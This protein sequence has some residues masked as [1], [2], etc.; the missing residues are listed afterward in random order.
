MVIYM[1]FRLPIIN[2]P[3]SFNSSRPPRAAEERTPPCSPRED[4]PSDTGNAPYVFHLDRAALNSTDYRRALWTGNKLQLV[5][6]RIPQGEEI[7]EEI[8]PDTDQF[9]KIVS[10]SGVVT[11]TDE[12][13]GKKTVLP[14]SREY[15]ALIPKGTRHN[16][17]NTGRTPLILYSIY[18]PRE[19]PYG[20]VQETKQS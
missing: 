5:S 15:A 11:F 12:H 2:L 16:I 14:I 17:K 4:A 20:T 6:M 8:H 13:T 19:H 3:F 10:G 7:G 9:I 18:A 1:K